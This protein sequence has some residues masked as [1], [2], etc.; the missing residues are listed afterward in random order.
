MEAENAHI[1]P[2]GLLPKYFAGEDTPEEHKLVEEWLYADEK[3]RAEFEAFS[4][5]WNITGRVNDRESIDIDAEWRL[6]EAEMEPTKHKSITFTRILQIAASVILISILGLAGFKMSQVKTEKAPVAE[7]S[8]FRMPDGSIISMNAGSGISYRKDFGRTNRN[9]SLKGEA[10][11]E[12]SRNPELPFVI[13]AGEASIRVTGTKFNVKAYKGQSE[14]KVSVTEGTVT[15][16][17]TKNPSRGTMLHAG[18]TGIFDRTKKEVKMQPV[19]D[20]NDISWKTG[21][22]DFNH[23]SL[24]EVADIIENTYH[25]RVIVDP[26]VQRCLITVLFEHENL[27]AVLTVLKTTLDLTVTKKDGNIFISGNGC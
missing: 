10:Y 2:V 16:Y 18:E 21:I 14:I 22:M 8:A 9:I 26:S 12:V 19:M 20:M 1:D 23:S 24:A 27:D 13:S 7:L 17:E 15:L 6:M 4:K 3:N 25:C 5:L 11:F